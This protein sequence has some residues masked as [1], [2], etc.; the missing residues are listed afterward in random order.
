MHAR[1]AVLFTYV[2]YEHLIYIY[3]YY[4]KCY[5]LSP[6]FADNLD[7]SHKSSHTAYTVALCPTVFSFLASLTSALGCIFV[8][9]AF[10]SVVVPLPNPWHSCVVLAWVVAVLVR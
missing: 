2:L 7:L 5:D 1:A 4:C 3:Q 9:A 8:C 6:P 10:A